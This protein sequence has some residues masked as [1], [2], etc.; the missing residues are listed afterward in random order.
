[1]IQRFNEHSPWTTGTLEI[2][3]QFVPGNVLFLEMSDIDLDYLDWKQQL[4]KIELL[5]KQKN[6]QK[7]LID[8]GLLILF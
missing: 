4:I 3:K 2:I 6:I 7:I 5:V 8:L 1:M